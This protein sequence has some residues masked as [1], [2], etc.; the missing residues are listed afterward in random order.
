MNRAENQGQVIKRVVNYVL[1][2]YQNYIQI[3]ILF[4][5]SNNRLIDELGANHD[6]QGRLAQT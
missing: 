1:I 6:S 5:F 3:L 2:F 4:V